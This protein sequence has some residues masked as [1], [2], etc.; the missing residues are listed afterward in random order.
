LK[1]VVAKGGAVRLRRWILG[2]VGFEGEKGLFT[3]V[4]KRL[5]RAFCRFVW[6]VLVGPVDEKMGVLTGPNS[7]PIIY[8]ALRH[9]N[10]D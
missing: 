9:A 1:N 7:N 3:L 5:E 6:G 10:L 4:L 8:F 2:D